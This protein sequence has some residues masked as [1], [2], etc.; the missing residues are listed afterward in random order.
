MSNDDI[1]DFENLSNET[2]ESIYND[3]RN[4]FDNVERKLNDDLSEWT[5]VKIPVKREFIDDLTEVV[6]YEIRYRLYLSTVY[7]LL[8]LLDSF[9]KWTNRY[10]EFYWEKDK[11]GNLTDVYLP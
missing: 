9:D 6:T 3:Q 2:M 4:F 11:D 7:K 1:I 5:M 10:S 8:G